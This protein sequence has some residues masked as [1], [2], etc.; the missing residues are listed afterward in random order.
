V[1]AEIEAF[2]HLVLAVQADVSVKGAMQY[3]AEQYHRQEGGQYELFP[4]RD[5]F[6]VSVLTEYAG[7]G[8]EAICLR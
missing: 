4:T 3:W 5:C 1:C 6:G 8:T 7:Y 2:G